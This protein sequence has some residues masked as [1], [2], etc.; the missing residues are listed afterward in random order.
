MNEK[1]KKIIII[2]A[3]IAVAIILVIAVISNISIEKEN[4]NNIIIPEEEISDAQFRETTVEL[5]FINDDNK[6]A[7]VMKKLDSKELL[8]NPYEAVINLLINE[9]KGES[10]KS[11]IPEN[12]KLNEVKKDGDCLTIDL[13]KEFI[14]SNMENE[15]NIK[16]SINQIVYTVTQFTEIDKVKILIDGNENE[17]IGNE[18]FGRE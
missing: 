13:S 1:N 2:F 11:L 7:P 15:E 10:F 9:A 12:T 5:F 18:V 8:E 14:D 4:D 3:A 6:I 17:T 16:Q